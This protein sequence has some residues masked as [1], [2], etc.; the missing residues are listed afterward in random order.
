[1][2][3]LAKRGPALDRFVKAGG[4]PREFGGI[5]L[6]GLTC[7]IVGYGRIG[8]A[9][10]KR[11]AA[12]DMKIVVVDPAF[13]EGKPLNEALGQAD[14]IVLACSLNPQTRGVINAETLKLMKRSAFVVNIARG[15]VI[16]E[17]ALIAALEAGNLAGAGLDVLEHEPP[18]GDN[19]LL[20]RDDVVLTPHVAAYIDTAFDRMAIACAQNALA[21]LDGKLDAANVVNPEVLATS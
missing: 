13:R 18:H 7:A 2:L 12:F 21:G 20:G 15:P 8:R 6:A 16:D 14:F 9:I 17:R 19:P 10:A 11:V 1:M 3:A 4:W 5:E